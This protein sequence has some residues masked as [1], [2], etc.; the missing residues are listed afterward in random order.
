MV[1]S[2]GR[3]PRRPVPIWN[4]KGLRPQAFSLRLEATPERGNCCPEPLRPA[5]KAAKSAA[6][7]RNGIHRAKAHFFVFSRSSIAPADASPLAGVGFFLRAHCRH[8]VFRV[9][10]HRPPGFCASIGNAGPRLA[11]RCGGF[12][13]HANLSRWRALALD[14]VRF[15]ARSAAVGGERAGGVLCQHFFQLPA[16]RHRRRRRRPGLAGAAV[17]AIAKPDRAVDFGRPRG[18]GR[19][20]D[21]ARAGDLAVDLQSARRHRMVRRRRDSYRRCAR[22]PAA[23]CHR[24]PARA[25]AKAATSSIMSCAW[26]RSCAR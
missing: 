4:Q 25:M 9:P 22:H 8:A 26:R 3:V 24:T 16:V 21:H 23:R 6:S 2:R 7:R 5:G 1:K 17:C 19:R 11:R 20:L 10:G 14:P 15:D 18:D 12:P 13:S